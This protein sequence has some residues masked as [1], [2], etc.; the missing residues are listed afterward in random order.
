M[1]FITIDLFLRSITSYSPIE[2][3]EVHGYPF[4]LFFD[5]LD[6]SENAADPG[7]AAPSAGA[8]A[9]YKVGVVLGEECLELPTSYAAIEK[10]EEKLARKVGM[11]YR[12]SNIRAGGRSHRNIEKKKLELALRR[13]GRGNKRAQV[14]AIQE[15]TGRFFLVLDAAC[16]FAS[17]AAGV[18]DEDDAAETEADSGAAAARSTSADARGS[19]GSGGGR[20]RKRRPPP[21]S[22]TP[23]QRPTLPAAVAAAYADT[24]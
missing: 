11:T 16:V 15:R 13:R 6:D 22:R 4:P 3:C 5:A 18:A 2:Y 23:G 21:A 24:A 9:Q 14:A 7:G 17:E 1:K 20:A 12:D 10:G 8:A 19:T